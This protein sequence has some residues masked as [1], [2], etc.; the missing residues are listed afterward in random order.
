LTEYDAS[1]CGREWG[2]AE[3]TRKSAVDFPPPTCWKNQRASPSERRGLCW[4]YLKRSPLSAYSII[5][6]D[7]GG[8]GSQW[9]QQPIIINQRGPKPETGRARRHLYLT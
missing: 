1:V 9:V 5:C 6:G 3:R 8:V 2:D 4:M 7:G